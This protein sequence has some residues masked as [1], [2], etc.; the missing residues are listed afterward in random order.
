MKKIVISV[1]LLLSALNLPAQF[2]DEPITLHTK[3]GE[4]KGTLLIPDAAKKFNVIILH[5]GSGPTDRNGNNPLGVKAKSYR[6]LAEALIKKKIAILLIDKRGVGAS[7][8]AGKSEQEMLF[9]D[10]VNDLADWTE[11]M[12]KDKRVKKTFLAGHS[13]GAL[14]A[15]LAAQ[16]IKVNGYISVSGIA[17]PIDRVIIWQLKQQSP[18]TSLVADSMF[19]RLKEGK[20]LDSIPPALFMLLRPSIHPYMASWMKYNPCEE[21]KK[22]TLPVL[23]LQGNTDIQV[24]EEEGRKLHVCNPKTSLVIINGMN[25]VLKEAPADRKKNMATYTDEKLPI[26]SELVDE[27]VKFVK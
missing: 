24:A 15:M 8:N 6:L 18:Q 16:K 3:T 25:H 26:K 4:L 7:A 5:P 1:L 10:Y 9:D 11:L 14:V 13:E 20:K 2:T 27:M 19:T 21:I 17:D 23:I 12:K 22:L